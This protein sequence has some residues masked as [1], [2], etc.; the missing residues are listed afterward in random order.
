[1]KAE[2]KTNHKVTKEEF[3]VMWEKAEE[4]VQGIYE[5]F[6]GRSQVIIHYLI[7]KAKEAVDNTI[8][9]AN[10]K[11]EQIKDDGGRNG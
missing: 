4:H 3:D 2:F 9:T 5:A 6:G 11:Y 1:M 7:A 10:E 8:N